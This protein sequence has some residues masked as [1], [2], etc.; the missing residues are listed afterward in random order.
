MDSGVDA[1]AGPDAGCEPEASVPD[2]AIA[3]AC[4]P[5]PSGSPRTQVD[6]Q[7]IDGSSLGLIFA[8]AEVTWDPWACSREPPILE[9]ALGAAACG[10]EIGD[11]LV[12]RL[13]ASQL[14]AGRLGDGLPIPITSSADLEIRLLLYSR[15]LEFGSC[16]GAAGLLTM[17]EGG[18]S[19]GAPLVGSFDLTLSDCAGASSGTLLLVR[20]RFELTLPRSLALEC[21][22]RGAGG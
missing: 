14:G 19:D 13:D 2:G 6:V 15:G 1:G 5:L 8:R 21:A 9:I 4:V 11:R 20:G 22:A 3:G 12:F 10:G 17:E 7:A 18:L 16:S